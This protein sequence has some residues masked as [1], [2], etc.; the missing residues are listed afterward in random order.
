[1]TGLVVVWYLLGLIVGILGALL[2]LRFVCVI[3]GIPRQIHHEGIFK[4]G[5]PETNNQ[6]E[7]TIFLLWAFVSFMFVVSMWYF[8]L[9]WLVGRV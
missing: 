1:M 3:L 9:P 8:A 5:F 6:I 4:F 7:R 2:S